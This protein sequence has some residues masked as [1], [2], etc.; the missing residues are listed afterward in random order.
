MSAKAKAG[1]PLER[2]LIGLTDGL[3]AAVDDAR[4]SQPRAVFIEDCLWLLIGSEED[5]KPRPTVGTYDREEAKRKR[6]LKRK[7][8]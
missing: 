8:A 7:E 2:K 3:W 4:G 1:P 5:R 6:Q